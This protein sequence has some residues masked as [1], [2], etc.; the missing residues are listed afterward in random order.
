MVD[1]CSNCSASGVE[2]HK[3]HIVPRSR[4]GSDSE[5]NLALLCKDC[6]GQVHDVTFKSD[7]GVVKS[8]INRS[9]EKSKLAYEFFNDERHIEGFLSE[10]EDANSDMYNFLIYGLLIGVVDKSFIFGLVHPEHL[11]KGGMYINFKLENQRDLLSL[12]ERFKESGV[13]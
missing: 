8:G 1:K 13:T 7:L 2:M 5:S 12:Y 6:H 9:K 4:G 11:T 3:H 10:L